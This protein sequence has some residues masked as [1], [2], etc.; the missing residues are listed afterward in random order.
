M[1]ELF[2][3]EKYNKSGDAKVIVE[4]LEKAG[5]EAYLVGGVVRDTVLGIDNK[6]YDIC[7]SASPND[8]LSIFKNTKYHC[9]DHSAKHGMIAIIND[10]N[11]QFEI[12]T[13]RG[14]N[15]AEDLGFRDFTINAMAYS[16]RTGLIDPYSGLSD[17]N[18]ATLRATKNPI[19]RFKED[20]IRILRGIR[21]AAQYMFTI[22]SKTKNCMHDVAISI[23]KDP[24]SEYR[25][26]ISQERIG[27]EL[28]KLLECGNAADI[29]F[30]EPEILF[31]MI[32]EM[33]SMYHYDQNNP[34][35]VNDLLTHTLLVL[36]GIENNT[37]QFGPKRSA[38]AFMFAALFHDIGKI[39]TRSE[40]DGVSH[41]FGHE[42]V[43]A[44]IAEDIMKRIGVDKHVRKTATTII[45]LHDFPV[46]PQ[47][48][49]IL[50]ML[51]KI[52]NNYREM[53]PEIFVDLCIFKLL[54]S[55]SHLTPEEFKLAALNLD[56]L[57]NLTNFNCK[58][59]IN[60]YINSC[61]FDSIPYSVEMLPITGSDIILATGRKAG[62][63]VRKTLNV[64]LRHVM[65]GSIGFD[66]ESVLCEA[67]K[68]S[69]NFID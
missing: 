68:L 39:E 61:M 57:Q 11:E 40:K 51:H 27:K 14:N 46:E 26:K 3:E 49:S 44:E 21:F 10:S 37:M 9:L 20:P 34:H 18:H 1:Y 19:D 35:H 12:S 42:K 66:R 7:T 69:R 45:K 28:I 60:I 63:W 31:A 29:L 48:S 53:A 23:W 16:P 15:I 52:D 55:A 43:S 47:L 56:N 50:R 65:N 38:L 59:I 67:L 8:V 22:E 4:A 58:E 2:L 41:Y 25:K 54:D 30:D 62:P 36:Y 64:T 17:L 24:L 32:P 13:L 5:Y 6:D 33:A